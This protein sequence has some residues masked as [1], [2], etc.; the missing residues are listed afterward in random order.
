[1]PLT[2]FLVYMAVKEGIA[3]VRESFMEEQDEKQ[4]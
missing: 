3:L 1:M 4:K 2:T